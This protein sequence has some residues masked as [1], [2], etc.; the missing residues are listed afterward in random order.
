MQE[1]GQ[2]SCKNLASLYARIHCF[3]QES[4]TTLIYV[5]HYLMQEAC[6]KAWSK[7]V[8]VFL[9]ES[10]A[11]LLCKKLARWA[12]KWPNFSQNS[13]I[14]ASHAGIFARNYIFFRQDNQHNLV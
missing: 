10:C 14:L 11:R 3:M 1:S 7:T 9:Q 12:R 6:S 13:N 4:C 8:A 5:L 2:I